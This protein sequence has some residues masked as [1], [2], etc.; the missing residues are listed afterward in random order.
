[1]NKLRLAR[2]RCRVPAGGVLDDLQDLDGAEC[3]AEAAKGRELVVV[4]L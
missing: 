1:M 4:G 3:G 2:V